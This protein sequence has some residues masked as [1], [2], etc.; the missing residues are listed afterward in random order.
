MAAA[1]GMFALPAAAKPRWDA[2]VSRRRTGGL[3][4]LG[5]AFALAAAAGRPFRILLDEGVWEEK[6]RLAVP[7]VTI[8][9]TGPK[10][11]LS[12]GAASGH[13]KPDGAGQYGTSGS[14][15]LTIDAP[16]VTL[17]DLTVRNSFDYV[18]N[19][20]PGGI[21][22]GQA[23]ALAIQRGGDRTRVLR[24]HFEGY[25]DTLLVNARASFGDCRISGNVDFIFGAG[26]SLF[27]DCEIVTRYVPDAPTG[28]FLAAP[29][30][31]QDQAFGLTFQ[32]CR[33]TREAGVPDH[34]TY[35][36]RP[37][38]AG[39]NMELLG[40]A[41]FLDCAMDRHIH[42]EGWTWMGY[43]G[44]GGEQRQ[45]TPQEARLFEYRSR[46]P[47]A[48]PSQPTRRMLSDEEAARYTAE[49]ILSGWSG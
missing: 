25:Q 18:A 20:R 38:R 13:D 47:G 46:G 24:C 48:G 40:A 14:A 34:S 23:V 17:Q 7:D 41:A 5:E 42:P 4:T 44:P 45:L 49:A 35:L 12:F 30:T 39:G 6:L 31:H 26:A 15:S 11:I 29:S 21:Q 19:R 22:N 37:W 43:K 27:R 10:S 36:G 28:G 16:G 33:I 2:I 9:G 3:A 8:G 1:A 32:R